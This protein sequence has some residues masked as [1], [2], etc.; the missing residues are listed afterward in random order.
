MGV[1]SL[2][3]K[4]RVDLEPSNQLG[5][6]WALCNVKNFTVLCGVCYRPPNQSADDDQVFFDSLQC[7]LDKI[8]SCGQKFSA[9][10]L[11]GDCKAHYNFSNSCLLRTDIGVKLFNFLECP[12]SPSFARFCESHI[13]FFNFFEVSMYLAKVD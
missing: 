1:E 3:M 12:P 6:L 5:V 10:V 7:C 11:L 4:R 8:F 9:I 2:F 13:F